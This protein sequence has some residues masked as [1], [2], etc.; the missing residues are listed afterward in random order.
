MTPSRRQ[1]L[2]RRI[3]SELDG[4]PEAPKAKAFDYYVVMMNHGRRGQEAIV[5]PEITR[6]EV[7]RRIL[8]FEYDPEAVSFIHHVSSAGVED[9]TFA[10]MS[11]CARAALEEVQPIDRQAAEWDHQRDLRKHEAV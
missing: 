11:D 7:V 4:M 8:T 6:R 3:C 1:H 10:I 9:V 2:G 5:D